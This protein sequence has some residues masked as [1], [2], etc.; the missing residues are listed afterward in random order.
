M[1]IE[2]RLIFRYFIRGLARKSIIDHPASRKACD[3]E[4][5]LLGAGRNGAHVWRSV[6]CL[7]GQ[8]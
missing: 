4:T 3:A 2:M 7:N 5:S 6:G 1:L 8:G